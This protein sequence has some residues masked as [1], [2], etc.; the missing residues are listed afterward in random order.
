MKLKMKIEEIVKQNFKNKIE[1]LEFFRNDFEKTIRH[2]ILDNKIEDD[3][4]KTTNCGDFNF[5]ASMNLDLSED[6]IHEIY[7]L[8]DEM[9]CCLNKYENLLNKKLNT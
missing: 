5:R 1:R 3:L 7:K 2:I 4:I 6:E 9:I 8:S